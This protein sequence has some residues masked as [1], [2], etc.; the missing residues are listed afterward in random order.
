[1]FI[2]SFELEPVLRVDLE[3]YQA[4]EQSY[5]ENFLKSETF[6]SENAGTKSIS[7]LLVENT[8]IGTANAAADDPSTNNF[9]TSEEYWYMNQDYLSMDMFGDSNLPSYGLNTVVVEGHRLDSGWDYNPE[10]SYGEYANTVG[11]GGGPNSDPPPCGASGQDID[12]SF[13]E[14]KEGNTTQGVVPD[15]NNSKSGVTIGAGFDLG[16]RSL[17]DLNK[18]GIDQD[19]INTLSP[20]LGKTGTAAY[21]Y[22]QAH[23]LVLDFVDVM[24]LNSAVHSDSLA[25]VVVAYDGRVGI[26]AFYDL[27]T[28]AQTV[29]FSVSLQYGDLAVKT[30][31]FWTQVINK[32]WSGAYNNLMNFGDRYPTRRESEAELLKDAMDENRLHNGSSC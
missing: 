4:V 2:E 23:P 8:T 22:E 11:G 9:T 21:D 18:L 6:Q 32:D 25:K 16:Q 19:L 26:G 17:A 14:S 3:S 31:S 29:I 15:K 7:S 10:I 30:P 12:W 13:I 1:M 20:Y 24:N 5:L 28:E 27:P